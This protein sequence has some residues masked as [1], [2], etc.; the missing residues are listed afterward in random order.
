MSD[1]PAVTRFAPSPTGYLHLGN[2][3]TAFFN[4]LAARATG[5]RLVLRIEDTDAERSDEGLLTQL[6]A[7]LRW[8]G[9]E[10]EEGPDVGGEHAPYRQ[11]ERAASY[12]DAVDALR[13]K[14]LVYPCFCTQEELQLSRR[15]Q[16]AAGRPPRYAGTCAKLAPDEIERRLA[17]GRRAALRFRVPAG[18][19]VEFVDAIHGQQRFATDDIGDFVVSRADGSAAFFLGNAVDDAEMGITLVLRGDDHLANTPRQML[20]L[21]ALGR[22]V[23]AY[24]HLPLV[25]GASGTPLS[26]REGAAGLHELRDRGYLPAALRNYLL[27]LGHT[28]GTD[29]W[30]EAGDLS[31]HFDL[32]RISHSPARFDEAQLRHWQREAITHASRE[33]LMAWLGT[34]LDPLGVASRKAEFVAAVRGNLLFPSDV[35]PLVR[36][37]CEELAP[38]DADAINAVAEAGGVFFA[39]AVAEWTQH[40]GDFKAWTR[41]VGVATGRKGAALFMPLRAALTGA[42]HGPELAPLAALMGRE[43]VA[44]RLATARTLAAGS[45]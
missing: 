17:E 2:A 30:L 42:T 25:L 10:W 27:R 9:L 45:R 22:R 41:A 3:R 13:R 36:A 24:G 4:F 29:A 19:V 31:R 18:R 33:M 21:E 28:C 37:V 35:E 15:A 23:P 7:D 43:R 8:L 40:A 16:L 34:R 11:S 12:A 14:G 5:G 39:A 38:L 32:G 6:L 1:V 26:K 20:L 44:A